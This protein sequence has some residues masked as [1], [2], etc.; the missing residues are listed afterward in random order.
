MQKAILTVLLPDSIRQ[1]GRGIMSDDNSYSESQF[2]TMKCRP[3]FP[4]R[5]GSIEDAKAFCQ[6]FFSWY[7][8]EHY[9]SG[10]GLLTP[11]NVHYGKASAI[12]ETRKELLRTAMINIQN[13][14]RVEYHNRC[15]FLMLSGSISH[16][17]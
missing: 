11:E 9:H 12:I 5:F 3:E 15:S 6:T 4:D 14:S 7:N 10:L 16:Y 8:T 13:G 17:L 2:K 1:K